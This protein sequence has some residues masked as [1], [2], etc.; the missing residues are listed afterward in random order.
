M[1]TMLISATAARSITRLHRFLVCFM[2]GP[3]LLVVVTSTSAG[4][5][6]TPEEGSDDARFVLQPGETRLTFFQRAHLLMEI[7]SGLIFTPILGSW[8]TA[9]KVASVLASEAVTQ[10]K[11]QIQTL[12]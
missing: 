7:P 2:C 3:L 11:K 4:I 12:M 9:L 10:S 1:G 6:G 5:T 8:I